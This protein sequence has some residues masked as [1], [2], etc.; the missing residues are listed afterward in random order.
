MDG[1]SVYASHH[2]DAL[3]IQRHVAH[4][5]IADEV[6]QVG[7]ALGQRLNVLHRNGRRLRQKRLC[8]GVCQCLD[9]GV[10]YLPRHSHQGQPLAQTLQQPG[11]ALDHLRPLRAIGLGAG[12]PDQVGCRA[13][14]G[15]RIGMLRTVT[16]GRHGQHFCPVLEKK[17]TNLVPHRHVLEHGAQLDGV[18]DGQC[19]FLLHLL[20]HA[21]ELGRGL[22][23]GE[24]L[25]QKGLKL[26]EH[27]LKNPPAGFR[28][29]L[30]HLHDALDFCLQRTARKCRGVKTQ[31][32]RTHP[33]NELARRVLH[34]AE[35]LGLSQ[36]HTQHRHLQARKP[37]SHRGWNAVLRQDAL[38]HQGHHLDDGLFTLAVSLLLELRGPI[39]H[40]V[41][42]LYHG[43]R[44]VILYGSPHCAV[45]ALRLH[46]MGGQC[47]GQ[48]RRCRGRIHHVKASGGLGEQALELNH[49]ALRTLSR[50]GQ[51][52]R[53]GIHRWHGLLHGV[54]AGRRHA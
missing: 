21:D 7:Q 34:V 51:G 54:H 35:E 29:L 9:L 33:V 40:H 17:L 25:G 50:T 1:R 11:Q 4:V 45:V 2:L 30:D 32:D 10:L 19:L 41:G 48:C 3:G 22:L 5:G 53:P 13:L 38:E 47:M 12:R 49:D 18:L 46:A 52:R 16:H 39:A 31:C 20:C 37:D 36:R 24:E 23:G 8:Q 26:I 14:V 42:H 15:H 27:Q 6:F 44:A 28:I 43:R